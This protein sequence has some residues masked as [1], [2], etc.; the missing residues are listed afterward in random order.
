LERPRARARGER[1]QDQPFD[2]LRFLSREQVNNR[3]EQADRRLRQASESSQRQRCC[4]SN[5]AD[6]M[7]VICSAQAMAAKIWALSGAATP[8]P[9]SPNAIPPRRQIAFEH[10]WRRSFVRAV[11]HVRITGSVRQM[12]HRPIQIP[13]PKSRSAMAWAACSP[14]PVYTLVRS[15]RLYWPYAEAP[16]DLRLPRSPHSLPSWPSGK[17]L[18]LQFTVSAIGRSHWSEM[19]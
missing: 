19:D 1:D 4:R 3:I 8:M 13:A 16:V 18:W 7:F 10:Q 17:T 9:L 6:Y 5:T 14:P 2:F 12:R 11:R 15:T